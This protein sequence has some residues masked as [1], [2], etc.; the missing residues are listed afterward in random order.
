MYVAA[1]RNRYRSGL[2]FDCIYGGA[3]A[4]VEMFVPNGRKNFGKCSCRLHSD[5]VLHL[6][7]K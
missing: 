5:I 4:V 3:I 6:I 2:A 7:S 1:I